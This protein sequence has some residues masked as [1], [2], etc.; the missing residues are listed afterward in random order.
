[1]H[2]KKQQD[3]KVSTTDKVSHSLEERITARLNEL[4]RSEKAVARF[5]AD[6]PEKVVLL[7]ALEI[8]GLLKTSDAT[9]IRTAQSLGYSGLGELRDELVMSLFP[10]TPPDIR[11]R[12]TLDQIASRPEDAI[13]HSLALQIE[14]IQQAAR[15]IR[16]A[17]FRR[18]VEIIHDAER[19]CVFGIG[20]SAAMVQY[21]VL[22]LVRFGRQALPFTE[23][24]VRLSDS[25]LAMRSGDVLVA[26]AYGR[27]SVEVD[28]ATR[29]ARK[30][31]VPIVL[32]TDRLSAAL[33]DRID[34]ALVARR[35][36]PGQLTTLGTTLAIIDALLFALASLDRDR[37]VQALK[38][39]NDIRA[40]LVGARVDVDEKP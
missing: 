13:S 3:L 10:S 34:V 24:G 18:A 33:E 38:E 6:Q 36:G 20:P 23:T 4:T 39:L 2:Y 21:L 31:G 22:R 14:L 5:F 19:A 37:T 17:D 1:M 32:L 29:H 12:H 26:L 16:P 8:A 35:G 40:A 9:V 11:L 7:S 28:V 15:T 25:L 30:K 27:V